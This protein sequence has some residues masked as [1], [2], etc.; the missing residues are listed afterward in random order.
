MY[1]RSQIVCINSYTKISTSSINHFRFF[2]VSSFFC[3]INFWLQSR[4]L[5]KLKQLKQHTDTK[6]GASNDSKLHKY[7]FFNYSARIFK[8]RILPLRHWMHNLWKWCSSSVSGHSEL[9]Y[10]SK[11]RG[12]GKGWSFIS[13]VTGAL[14]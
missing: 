5:L 14:C 1:Q 6:H 10:C 3:I 12:Q 2:I 11:L 7:G 13:K 9:Q 4:T 8:N